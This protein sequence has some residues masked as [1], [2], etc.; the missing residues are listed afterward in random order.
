ME[1]RT[2][3]IAEMN[4]LINKQQFDRDN[5]AIAV[6][7]GLHEYVISFESNLDDDHEVGARLVT[8]GQSIQIHVQ[9]IG[10][11][12]PFLITFTG[13]DSTSSQLQL[14]QHVSQLSFLLVA[15]PKLQEKPFRV[16]FIWDK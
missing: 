11:K 5:P 6:F 4:R 15:V 16:G 2:P 9:S 10:F 12:A 7:K 8:F 1:V 3:L 14:V 13:V